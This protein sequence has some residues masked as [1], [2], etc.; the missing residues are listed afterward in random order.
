MRNLA[1]ARGEASSFEGHL[2]SYR[3]EPEL[4]RFR[5]TLEAQ[6]TFLAEQ[7]FVVLDHRLERDGATVILGAG[8]NNE[9]ED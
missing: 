9:Q 1:R 2:E 5:R 3:D 8:S 7:P 4:Y 6:E